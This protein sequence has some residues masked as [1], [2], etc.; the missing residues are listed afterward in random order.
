LPRW[1]QAIFSLI[2]KVHCFTARRGV[3]AA[4]SLLYIAG[5]ILV[6][7]FRQQV[8]MLAKVLWS[9]S[10]WL[11]L[12]ALAITAWQSLHQAAQSAQGLFR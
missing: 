12:K 6:T 8:R 10:F 5:A 7:A 1:S 4:A 3:K 9:P 11:Q 2:V